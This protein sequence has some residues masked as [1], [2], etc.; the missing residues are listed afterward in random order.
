MVNG[1]HRHAQRPVAKRIEPLS[2]FTS[3]CVSEDYLVSAHVIHAD[4]GRALGFEREAWRSILAEWA[5]GILALA[6]TSVLVA[7]PVAIA[8]NQF[9]LLEMFLASLGDWTQFR[10]LDTGKLV[11]SANAP[12]HAQ[13]L[14]NM[15][16]GEG[17]EAALNSYLLALIALD[18]QI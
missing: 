14:K 18:D 10:S 4:S 2:V 9:I 17:R 15:R 11:S 13:G 6:S 7:H 3:R 1:A 12:A 8:M 5:K 16:C